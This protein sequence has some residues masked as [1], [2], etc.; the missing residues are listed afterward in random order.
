MKLPVAPYLVYRGKGWV[1]QHDVF[2]LPRPNTI[3]YMEAKAW[4]QQSGIGSQ[5]EWKERHISGGMPDG[6]PKNPDSIFEGVF[7]GWGVFLGTGKM[8]GGW[9]MYAKA[10]EWAR[11]SGIRDERA[12]HRVKFPAGMRLPRHPEKSY[13]KEWEGWDVFLGLTQPIEMTG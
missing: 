3:P 6:M 12:W 1:G 8:R 13:E 5:K 11:Q 7:E 9:L 2:G 10:K 4:A